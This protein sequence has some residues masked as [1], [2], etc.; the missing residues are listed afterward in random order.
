MGDR[1]NCADWKAKE[2]NAGYVFNELRSWLDDNNATNNISVHLTN[3]RLGA[4]L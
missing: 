4:V 2:Y 1:Y 3:S